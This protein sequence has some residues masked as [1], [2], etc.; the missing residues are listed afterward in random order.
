MTKSQHLRRK[1][2]KPRVFKNDQGFYVIGGKKYSKLRGSREE[3]L[4]GVAYQT[5]GELKKTDLAVSKNVNHE[6]KLISRR[7]LLQNKVRSNLSRFNRL[8][9]RK[10]G[11]L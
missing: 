9:K 7:K 6:G 4:K 8:R 2:S 10:R 5:K 11:L 1:E 3:V